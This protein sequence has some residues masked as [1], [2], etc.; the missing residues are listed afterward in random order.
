MDVTNTPNLTPPTPQPTERIPDFVHEVIKGRPPQGP[1]AMGQAVVWFARVGLATIAGAL[2]LNQKPTSIDLS[3]NPISESRLA[4]V[5][6]LAARNNQASL[7]AIATA[8][9]EAEVARAAC[10]GEPDE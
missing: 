6:E 7:E 8:F 3:D 10:Q 2:E 5:N 9:L 1:G 4:R